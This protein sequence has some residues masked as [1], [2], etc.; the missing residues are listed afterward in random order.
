[1][2][3][4]FDIGASLE[5][6]LRRVAGEETAS[7]RKSLSKIDQDP[8]EV[9]HDLR[10]RMKKVRGLLRLFRSGL[11]KTYKAENAAARDIAR[12]FSDI[13]DAQVMVGTV[14][15]ICAEDGADEAI[16]AP[17]RDWAQKRRRRVLAAKGLKTRAANARE[18]LK[19]LQDRSKGWKLS[20]DPEAA[21]E[22]GLKKTLGRA[23]EGFDIARHGGSGELLHEWRKRV[24]YHRYHCR[25]IAPAWPDAIL[26]RESLADEVA[27]A[28]GTDRDLLV[29][30]QTMAASASALPKETV[31]LAGMLSLQLGDRLRLQA[32]AE[33]PKLFVNQADAEAHR[34]ATW[35]ALAAA[36]ARRG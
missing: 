14:D 6:N 19:A 29:L 33:A 17:L 32:L 34:M 31:H 35:W 26:A 1:M 28:I 9:V 11:G 18:D 2:S 7:A 3:Y 8:E 36:N 12:G 27:E 5:D 10:K 20:G 24:K 13:R 22:A 23:A 15:L 16:L 25:L 4:V 21:L 30:R